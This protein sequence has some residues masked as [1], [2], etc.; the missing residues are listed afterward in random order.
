MVEP[1]PV[2]PKYDFYTELPKRQIDIQHES[3]SPRSGP[4]PSPVRTQPAL[5][6]LRKPMTPHKIVTTP[7]VAVKNP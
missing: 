5:D 4:Q 2:K 3:A 6:P 7:T 1:A